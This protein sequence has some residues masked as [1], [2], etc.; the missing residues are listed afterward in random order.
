MCRPMNPTNVAP[1]DAD[2][3]AF[4][5]TRAIGATNLPGASVQ[6][7]CRALNAFAVA[8]FS[9]EHIKVVAITVASAESDARDPI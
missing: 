7:V 8:G 3:R 2:A 5:H 4:Q 1:N 9:N 6:S